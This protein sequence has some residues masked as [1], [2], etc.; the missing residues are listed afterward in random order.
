MSRR[1]RRARG[2]R[3][4]GGRWILRLLVLGLLWIAGVALYILWVGEQDDTTP[5]DVA[6][7]LGAAA[8]HINPSPV[9]EER[10]RHGVDLYRAGR[11]RRLIFTGGYGAGAA[12]AES[13]VARRFASARG[14]A[15]DDILIETAS[16]TTRENLHEAA[17]LMRDNGLATAIVVSDPLHM[18]RGLR[19]ARE[20]GI[21]A[22]GSPTPTSRFR[23]WR[24]RGG[25]LAREVYFFHRDHLINLWQRVIGFDAPPA[26]TETP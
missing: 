10:I 19:L 14:V 21:D 1:R 24:A 11:V 5:R 9:F 4:S 7:V 17:R 26:T 12:Y 25:F 3:A 18:A 20:A 16:S 8:Y 15:E 13:Q 6:I 22:V 23:S 2:T